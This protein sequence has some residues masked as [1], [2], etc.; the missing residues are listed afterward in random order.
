MIHKSCSGFLYKASPNCMYLQSM[1]TE[2]DCTAYWCGNRYCFPKKTDLLPPHSFPQG[3][4]LKGAV[5]RG[6]LHYAL[7]L[8]PQDSSFQVAFEILQKKAEGG[9][10]KHHPH[11]SSR[12][13]AAFYPFYSG[14]V[15][16]FWMVFWMKDFNTPSIRSSG[17]WYTCDLQVDIFFIDQP[18]AFPSHLIP[19]FSIEKIIL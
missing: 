16:V 9:S 11:F 10:W 18:S 13:R 5:C 7:C 4:C 3:F 2:E 12:V 17:R 15:L 8:I 19:A 1:S 6:T 14:N